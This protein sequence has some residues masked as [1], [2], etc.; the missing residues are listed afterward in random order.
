MT[1]RYDDTT[2]ILL[3]F[4]YDRRLILFFMR[5][6]IFLR[7]FVHLHSRSD[8]KRIYSVPRSMKKKQM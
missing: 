4:E 7:D 2:Q 6:N 5:K 3:K 1:D 8:I